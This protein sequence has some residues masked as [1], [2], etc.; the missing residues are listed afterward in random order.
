MVKLLKYCVLLVS[1]TSVRGFVAHAGAF[2]AQL[3]RLTSITGCSSR[4]RGGHMT[5][6]LQYSRDCTDEEAHFELMNAILEEEMYEGVAKHGPFMLEFRNYHAAANVHKLVRFFEQLDLTE[7]QIDDCA[8]SLAT[9]VYH[10]GIAHELAFVIQQLMFK[11][12]AFSS[13]LELWAIKQPDGSISVD[14]AKLATACNYVRTGSNLYRYRGP[15]ASLLI[16][17]SEQYFSSTENFS[18]DELISS[19]MCNTYVGI[20]LAICYADESRLKNLLK[21]ASI[22]DFNR[23]IVERHELVFPANYAM[24]IDNE[25]DDEQDIVLVIET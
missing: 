1:A 16:G 23:H 2:A 11:E 19:V 3:S 4:I 24:T 12:A 5:S 17:L 18:E 20:T 13:A 8:L 6:A 7:Q 15:W 22:R 9:D 10:S 21:L 14:A 25:Y